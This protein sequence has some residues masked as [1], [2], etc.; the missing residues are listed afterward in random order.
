EAPP[1][2]NGSVGG[3][4]EADS[5]TDGGSADSGA[6]ASAASDAGAESGDP[7]PAEGAGA[8]ANQTRTESVRTDSS[9]RSGRFDN[10]GEPG[11]RRNR[12][13]R[14]R[15]RGPGGGGGGERDLQ[16]GGQEQQFQGEPVPVAGLLDLRDEGFGF[17][18][19]NGYLPSTRDVYVSISQV[20]RFALR[21]GDYVEGASRPAASNEKYPALLRIDSVSGMTPDEARAGPRFEDLTP[22]FPDQKLNLEVPGDAANMTARIVDLLS[23]IGKGQ[24]GLL[25]SPTK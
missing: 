23:P 18:R 17:L 10:S 16:G 19:A 1:S 12:R 15:E 22:L 6:P 21:K 2:G 14:G 20:R 3:E 13:R 4:P 8:V 11:N 5:E 9:D 7:S 25:D 24:L